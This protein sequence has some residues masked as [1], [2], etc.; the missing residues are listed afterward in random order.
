MPSTVL[1]TGCSTGCGYECAKVF[2]SNGWNVAATMRNPE[3]PGGKELAGLGAN[4]AVFRLDIQE[5]KTINSVLEAAA[6]KFGKI[7]VL[8]NNAGY[9]QNGLLEATS[10]E[11]ML[12]QFAVNVFGPIDMMK[13]TLPYLRSNVLVDGRR[14]TII[15]VGSGAGKVA[16]PCMSLYTSSKHALEGLTE[17]LCYELASQKI[18]VKQY[19]PTSAVGST[20]FINRATSAFAMSPNLTGYNEFVGQVFARFEKIGK[21]EVTL[22]SQKVA[23]GIFGAATDGTNQVHYYIG[24]SPVDL[25][26]KKKEIGDEAF[27]EYMKQ[28]FGLL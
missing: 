24:E 3:S 22:T 28:N 9:A 26:A 10:R 13:A 20:N 1:I 19:D 16:Y 18:S 7:D 17:S 14:G 11:Q 15:N 12:E 5:H 27:I 4:V 21:D 6:T 8:I 25:E 23:Q 2:A